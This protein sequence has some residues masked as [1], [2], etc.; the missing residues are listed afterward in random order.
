MIKYS[1]GVEFGQRIGHAVNQARQWCDLPADILTPTI[2]ANHASRIAEVHNLKITVY[3]EPTIKKMGMGG[4]AAVGAGSA[5]ECRFVAIEYKA[6]HKDALQ[7]CLPV[8]V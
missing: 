6:S 1:V 5:Q 2:L 3:D 7:L 4:L 8:K